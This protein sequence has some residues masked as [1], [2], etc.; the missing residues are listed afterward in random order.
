MLIYMAQLEDRIKVEQDARE[1]LTYNYDE[2]VNTGF[3]KLG[4]EA[5]ILS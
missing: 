3:D 4:G 1:T 5:Q 2:S